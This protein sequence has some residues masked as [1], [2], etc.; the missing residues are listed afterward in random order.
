[1]E[2]LLR[3]TGE[4]QRRDGQYETRWILLSELR[5]TLPARR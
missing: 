1:M 4:A 3:I 5:P 2:Q